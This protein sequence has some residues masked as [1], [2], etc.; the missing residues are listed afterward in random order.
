LKYFATRWK[1]ADSIPDGVI[2][3]ILP[4]AVWSWGS[5]QSRNEYQECSLRGKG[6]RC[7]GLT[8]LPP[9]CAEYFK[10]LSLNLLKLSGLIYACTGR[11]L[12]LPYRSTMRTSRKINVPITTF[13]MK[14]MK[15]T[16]N[17]IKTDERAIHVKC[18]G[19]IRY[20]CEMSVQSKLERNRPLG[21]GEKNSKMEFE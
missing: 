17:Y 10:N 12:P 4:V 18:T 16:Y 14:F 11:A 3:L 5:T 19:D 9:S 1:V 15:I 7:L 8:V 21:N 6:G 2:D 20:A 13:F